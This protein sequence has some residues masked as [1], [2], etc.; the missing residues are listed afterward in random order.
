MKFFVTVKPHARSEGIEQIDK[1]HFIIKVNAP[2]TEGKANA[3]AIKLL[4]QHFNIPQSRI[5]LLSGHRGRYK[6]IE[7]H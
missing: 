7:I 6:T 1:T 2:P 3:A 4:A 5:S